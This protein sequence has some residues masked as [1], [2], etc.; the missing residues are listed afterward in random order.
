MKIQDNITSVPMSM[1]AETKNL[2]QSSISS[3]VNSRA[4]SKNKK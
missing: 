2:P 1:Q 4:E 3:N